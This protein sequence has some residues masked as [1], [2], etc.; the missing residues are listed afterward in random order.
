MAVYYAVRAAV[1]YA[2]GAQ[3]YRC[4][5]GVHEPGV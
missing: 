4:G 3:P 1:E 2:H 5:T